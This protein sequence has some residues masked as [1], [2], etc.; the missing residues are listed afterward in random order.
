MSI[1][2]I[3]RCGCECMAGAERPEAAHVGDLSAGTLVVSELP[4]DPALHHDRALR[5][6][7][8]RDYPRRRARRRPRDLPD[9][10]QHGFEWHPHQGGR[11]LCLRFQVVGDAD[12]R[13]NGLVQRWRVAPHASGSVLGIPIFAHRGLILDTA[14]PRSPYVALQYEFRM[15]NQLCATISP[16]WWRRRGPG[17]PQPRRADAERARIRPTQAPRNGLT[18]RPDLPIAR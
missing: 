3:G 4:D 7:L 12:R 9:F 11:N 5:A 17:S 15:A 6:L 16:I 1:A 13:E 8:A 10:R 2:R 18:A 14:L